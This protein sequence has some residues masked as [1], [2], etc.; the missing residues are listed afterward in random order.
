LKLIAAFIL[1]LIALTA[2]AWAQE[3]QGP[4][5]RQPSTPGQYRPVMD[6]PEL[7]SGS[8]NPIQRPALCPGAR[9]PP[10]TAPASARS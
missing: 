3:V 9:A 10:K 7:P 8:V 6:V 4:G 1:S 5:I 2:P